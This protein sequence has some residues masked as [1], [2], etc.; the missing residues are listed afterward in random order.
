MY[1]RTR[2]GLGQAQAT[3]P[4]LQTFNRPRAQPTPIPYLG[5]FNEPMGK[6]EPEP[7]RQT[8]AVWGFNPN[9]AKLLD[10][11]K[12]HIKDIATQLFKLFPRNLNTATQMLRGEFLFE[13]HVDKKTDPAAYGTLD[14]DRAQ[15]VHG[16]LSKWF[17]ELNR[18]ALLTYSWDYN[19]SRAGSTRPFSSD[20]QRNRRVVICVRWK[21]QSK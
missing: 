21:V 13:G 5:N 10:F 7:C 8:W 4:T 12:R 15:A 19:H 11:Q 2:D 1:I 16:E 9:S 18:I 17:Y 3:W 20:S 14:M 6:A